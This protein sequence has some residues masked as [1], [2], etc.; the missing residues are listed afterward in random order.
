MND[1]NENSKAQI[2]KYPEK[3]VGPDYIEHLE[4]DQEGVEYVIGREH[5]NVGTSI[6]EG[7]VEDE[8]GED[9]TP[10]DTDRCTG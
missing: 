10:L 5:L 8:G 3:E 4:S 9:T 6:M 7:G 2:H 1:E